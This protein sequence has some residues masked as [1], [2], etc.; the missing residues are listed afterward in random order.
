MIN[1]FLQVNSVWF[2]S[3]NRENVTH[4]VC[5]ES[6]V[7]CFFLHTVQSIILCQR[8]VAIRSLT[9]KLLGHCIRQIGIGASWINSFFCT[10]WFLSKNREGVINTRVP[11]GSNTHWD[12]SSMSKNLVCMLL[13]YLCHCVMCVVVWA[14]L[15]TRKDC[16]HTR[17][18][19]V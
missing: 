10:V 19:K 15:T 12:L 13:C 2:V 16:R 7:C 8:I 5:H 11:L 17:L 1:R 18:M 3:K 14:P 4:N 6:I 9:H